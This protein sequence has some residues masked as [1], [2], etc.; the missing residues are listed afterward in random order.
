MF[1]IILICLLFLLPI[2]LIVV[3]SELRRKYK[4]LRSENEEVP[5]SV[6]ET[7]LKKWK[8]LYRGASFVF[9]SIIALVVS[10]PALFYVA[11]SF[12]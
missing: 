7:E 9:W 6:S 12:M 4:E 5:G 11:I 3:A 8:W 1:S 10:I 2:I